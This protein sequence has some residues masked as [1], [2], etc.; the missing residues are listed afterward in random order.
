M[1]LCHFVNEYTLSLFPQIKWLLISVHILKPTSAMGIYRPI[2]KLELTNQRKKLKGTPL[3]NQKA[4]GAKANNV[5]VRSGEGEPFYTIYSQFY[6]LS[7]TAV[8]Y[9]MS[10]LSGQWRHAPYKTKTRSLGRARK[11]S[12]SG[13]EV[14]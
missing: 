13:E 1:H 14:K 6:I 3:S 2:L 9:N 4:G 8:N 11:V 12:G 7:V 10:F 5:S